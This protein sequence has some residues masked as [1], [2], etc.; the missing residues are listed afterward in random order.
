MF[1]CFE[2]F[3]LTFLSS[4]DTISLLTF[5]KIGE[6]NDFK[7]Y[8]F[9]KYTIKYRKKQVL[10]IYLNIFYNYIINMWNFGF[11]K[12]QIFR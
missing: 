4:F 2:Y 3:I 8:N 1:Y 12:K 10:F 9:F 7:L 5:I 6:K 11:D